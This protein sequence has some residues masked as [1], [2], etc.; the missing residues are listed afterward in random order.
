MVTVLVTYSYLL[1][2]VVNRKSILLVYHLALNTYSQEISQVG[3]RAF[4]ISGV[5][6]V[7]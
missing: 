2:M 7:G 5:V 1:K 6:T 3:G 4:V